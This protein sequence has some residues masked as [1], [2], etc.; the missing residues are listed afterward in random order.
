MGKKELGKGPR[1]PEVGSHTI[2]EAGS[3]TAGEAGSPTA[4][5]AG[6]PTT[7]EARSPAAGPPGQRIADFGMYSQD[8]LLLEERIKLFLQKAFI[9]NKQ[10]EVGARFERLEYL[11]D[12]L[13]RLAEDRYR[14]DLVET[15]YGSENDGNEHLVE[16]K[17]RSALDESVPSRLAAEVETELLRADT[18]RAGIRN[19]NFPFMEL[20]IILL[21]VGILSSIIYLAPPPEQTASAVIGSALTSAAPWYVGGVLITL[22]G[23]LLQ[24]RGD[25]HV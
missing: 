13:E 11:A 22:I 18:E 17:H 16:H 3:P 5:N 25:S 14:L 23:V 1:D 12:R 20:S 9:E 8:W 21:F 4:S 2:G 15:R 24:R 6:L 10:Y 7:A 19:T